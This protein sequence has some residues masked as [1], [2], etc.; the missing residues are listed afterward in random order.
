MVQGPYLVQSG[1]EWCMHQRMHQ[2][3][4]GNKSANS[5]SFGSMQLPDERAAGTATGLRSGGPLRR[6]QGYRGPPPY[7]PAQRTQWNVVTSRFFIGTAAG[8]TRQIAPG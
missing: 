4:F 2:T 8:P 3:I 1:A 7:D 5:V 6:C